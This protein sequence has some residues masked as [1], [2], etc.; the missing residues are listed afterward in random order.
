MATK[1]ETPIVTIRQI[2]SKDHLWLACKRF[3]VGVVCYAGRK[4]GIADMK[5]ALAAKGYEGE[6]EIRNI[7]DHKRQ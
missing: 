3:G 1:T 7:E 2:S 4:T 5:K 6:F